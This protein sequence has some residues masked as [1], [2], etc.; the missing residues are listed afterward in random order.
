IISATRQPNTPGIG[1]TGTLVGVV[2]RGVAAGSSKLQIVQVNAKDSAQKPIPLVAGE[3]T[4][5]VQ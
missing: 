4:V 5:Q 2:I 3:S 1:G